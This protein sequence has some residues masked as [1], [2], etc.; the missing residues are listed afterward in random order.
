MTYDV[1]HEVRKVEQVVRELSKHSD[2]NK[3][4]I[5]DVMTELRMDKSRVKR[6]LAT[7]EDIGKVES[8]GVPIEAAESDDK[9]EWL[10]E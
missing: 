4:R 1:G 5:R 3:I 6:N 9:L 10:S 2:D 8:N 7:L